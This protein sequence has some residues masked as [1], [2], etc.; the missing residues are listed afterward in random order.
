MKNITLANIFENI[1]YKY[2][3]TVI[4]L[5]IC[6]PILIKATSYAIDMLSNNGSMHSTTSSD[7]STSLYNIASELVQDLTHHSEA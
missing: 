3:L 7:D 5:K 1:D 6:I 2:V 4:G